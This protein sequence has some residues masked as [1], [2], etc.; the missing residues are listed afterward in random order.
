M[1]VA[2]WWFREGWIVAARTHSQDR[3]RP[4]RR[5]TRAAWSTMLLKEVVCKETLRA[6]TISTEPV[7]CPQCSLMSVSSKNTLL[8]GYLVAMGAMSQGHMSEFPSHFHN[9]DPEDE[10]H[11]EELEARTCIHHFPVPEPRSS[12]TLCCRLTSGARTLGMG[13]K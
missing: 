1:Y 10:H 7:S 8:S 12:T 13:P 6:W 9:P 2:T 11:S 5:S 4:P 3:N